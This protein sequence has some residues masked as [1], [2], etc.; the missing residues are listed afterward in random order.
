MFED[1][2][3]ALAVER[4]RQRQHPPQQPHEAALAEVA[5]VVAPEG[6]PQARDD[7]DRPEDVGQPSELGE[8]RDAG[9]D[10][11]RAH[12]QGADDAP[13]EHPPLARGRDLERREDQDED[14]EVV[15]AQRLLDDVGGQEGH[16]VGAPELDVDAAAET[17]R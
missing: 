14:E 8:R 5:L 2:H 16:G 12:R 3:E 10:A 9:D 15:D 1:G 7:E 4:V 17:E 13:E 6:G 11:D